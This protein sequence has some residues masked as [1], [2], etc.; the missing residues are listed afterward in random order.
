[1]VAQAYKPSTW[2]VKAGRLPVQAETGAQNGILHQDLIRTIIVLYSATVLH[3]LAIHPLTPSHSKDPNPS[4]QPC[5]HPCGPAHCAVG[6]N[7]RGSP[8]AQPWVI[9]IAVTN[10]A[11]YLL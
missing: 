6:F 5:I 7:Y 11:L 1:M 3:K 4:G 8:G 2:E 9:P 10:T